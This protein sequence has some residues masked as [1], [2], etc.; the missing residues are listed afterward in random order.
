MN[1]QALRLKTAIN[2][3]TKEVRRVIGAASLGTI[4]EWYDFY[5]YGALVSILGK[6]FF[7]GVDPSLTLIF[8]LL[9]FAAG[10]IVRPFG[11]LVFGR[12]GDAI[13]RKYTFL[14]T[15]VIMG[16]ATVGV[17]LLPGYET[18]GIYAPI[19]LVILRMLQGLA[20]G[21][22]YGGAATYIAEFSPNGRRGENTSWLQSTGSLGLCLA[23]A[24]IGA[25]RYLTGDAFDDWGWRVPFVASI[26]LLLISCVIRMTMKESPA[27]ERLKNEGTLSKAPIKE[28]FGVW[29]NLKL[30]LI[31]FAA[32]GVGTPVVVYTASFYPL[33][34]L[35]ET[36]KVDAQ[37]ASTVIMIALL[38][39]PVFFWFFGRLSDKVGRKPV[40]LCG[41]I[42]AMLTFIPIYKGM[43]Y[44]ANPD[45]LLA[46]KN[47]PVVLYTKK[48][49]CSFQF[50]PIGNRNFT[51]SCDIAKKFLTL[52]S[53]N[54]ETIESNDGTTRIS[55]GSATP[56][57][58]TDKSSQP[59]AMADVSQKL[60]TAGYPKKAD[61]QKFNAGG[62][63]CLL[64]VLVIYM[65]MVYGPGAAALVE[66]FPTRIRY[67]A[68]SVPYH[69]ANGWVGGFLP[70]CAFA[71]IAQTG[72]MQA[73]L[74]YPLA[75]ILIA[76]T[77]LLIFFKD[78][79]LIEMND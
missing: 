41:Y 36:L 34:Y 74:W 47:A 52:N 13:G 50:N 65:G 40:M 69:V 62:V 5:L 11:A 64:I 56:T 60:Q 17:G 18:L 77:T 31:A 32:I 67:T 9:S 15:I 38:I 59:A 43:M 30:I 79:H 29:S 39:S 24:M 45:L 63:L 14:A 23:L 33:L 66:M 26:L 44:F 10:F 1:E 76:S 54:Y 4:F 6:H 2:M 35:T 78:R 70:T 28:A 57:L 75:W 7:S 71:L 55:V 53:L 73:G 3:D 37:Q 61:P 25:T 8:A 22:E 12:L 46:Q 49:D 42:L 19:T 58:I 27:F 72:N 21:G 20:I 48:E 16:L 51:S 68:M